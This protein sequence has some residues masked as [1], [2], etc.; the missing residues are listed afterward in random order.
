MLSPTTDENYDDDGSSCN[1]I[2]RN[3]GRALKSISFSSRHGD[4]VSCLT[5]D[6]GDSS[7][8]SSCS[9][10]CLF[11]TN[12]SLVDLEFFKRK[13]KKQGSFSSNNVNIEVPFG[14]PIE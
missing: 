3:K 8:Y 9:R 6:D 1:N 7:N 11:R 13:L 4:E 12:L 14:K 10:T 2:K 5:E